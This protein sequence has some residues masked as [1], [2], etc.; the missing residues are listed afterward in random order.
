MLLE[1][2]ANLRGVS[3][4]EGCVRR[5][6]KELLQDS[7][8]TIKTDSIGNLFVRKEG[9]RQ[10]CRLMLAAHMDEVGLMVT[11]VEKSGHLKFNPVGG[12]DSRILV[13][14]RVRIGAQGIPGVIGA[15]AIHLQKPGERNKPY[16]VEDMYIDIGVKKKEEAEK[17]AKV[18]DYVSFD[19]T[20]SKIGD[21]YWRGKAFDDRAGCAVLLELLLDPQLDGFDA[22]FTVQE[23]IGS[24]GA[25]TAAYTLR[26]ERA[27]VIEGTAAADTPGTDREASSTTLGAG[28][29][30]S[31]MDR[32]IIVDRTMLQELINAAQSAAIPFQFRRFTG[33]A[34]DAGAVALTG[35]GVKAAVVSVPCRYIHSPHSVLKE[36]DLQSTAALVK[37]WLMRSEK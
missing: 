24:R 6:I 13:A 23:E 20:C 18:G 29:A 1:K 10:G 28:P 32:S 15:K 31:V 12:I 11:A 17:L 8:V 36:S 30:L 25:L 27:L 26:P 35:E 22:V 21:G 3:G 5:A 16:E 33:G 34:T 2:L 9:S 37:A 7:P 4:D 19:S 14:K